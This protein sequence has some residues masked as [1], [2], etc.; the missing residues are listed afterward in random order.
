MAETLILS[1]Y[2]AIHAPGKGLK[3]L[4]EV[5]I[6]RFCRISGAKF[7]SHKKVL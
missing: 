3:P 4:N 6:N 1:L 2:L 5:I 7:A